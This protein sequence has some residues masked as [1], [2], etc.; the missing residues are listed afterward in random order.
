MS[1]IQIFLAKS[2]IPSSGINATGGNEV[3]VSAGPSGIL[4][5]R[6][7][8]TGPGTFTVNSA[9]PTATIDYIVVAGG[10]GGGADNASPATFGYSGAGGGAGGFRRGTTPISPGNYPVTIGAGGAGGTPSSPYGGNGGSSTFNTITSPGGGGGAGLPPSYLN[11]GGY[12][13][14]SGGSGGGSRRYPTYYIP[15]VPPSSNTYVSY[16]NV[17]T[18]TFIYGN[19][20]G[21]IP[22]VVPVILTPTTSPR[23]YYSGFNGSG[24]GGAL[25]KGP[26]PAPESSPGVGSGLS[27]DN[28]LSS[29][30]GNGARV[31]TNISPRYYGTSLSPAIVCFSGGGAGGFAQP[32]PGWYGPG[33][34]TPGSLYGPQPGS[35]G[36]GG[37]QDPTSTN[38]VP[39]VVNTGGGGGGYG[40]SSPGRN[41]GAGGPGIVIIAYD[42]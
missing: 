40:G 2:F 7:I 41:G 37:G 3:D 33:P 29:E 28:I 15:L 36:G 13:G 42:W 19:V 12:V 9:P 23:L 16:G 35:A 25:N 10:G 14:N 39:G 26:T 11:P 24:G 31:P 20:G 5:K 8:F 38:G 30:G 22:S 21:A 32:A 6:H 27:P 4:R 34:G 1:I 18:P 17:D